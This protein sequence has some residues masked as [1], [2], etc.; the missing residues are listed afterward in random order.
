MSRTMNKLLSI[1]LSMAICLSFIPS[2]YSF[3][4]EFTPEAFDVM[5]QDSLT[6]D[7]S[8]AD[9]TA[10]EPETDV[11]WFDQSSDTVL[12]SDSSAY[13][14]SDYQ[15]DSTADVAAAFEDTAALEIVQADAEVL[16]E[17][18]SS[19]SDVFFT[20][21]MPAS[22]SAE[23][24]GLA[25]EAVSPAEEE[26]D[27]ENPVNEEILSDQAVSEEFFSDDSVLTADAAELSVTDEIV[28][29]PASSSSP[30]A[31]S[32][33]TE[34]NASAVS[35]EFF[36]DDSEALIYLTVSTSSGLL[37]L[38]VTD[39]ETGS[40]Q[41][42][43]YL[44]FPG[45][46][47]YSFHDD[48]GRYADMQEAFTVENVASQSFILT[49]EP[50]R[51][52]MSFSTAYV[53]PL[54]A[55]VITEADLPE[56]SVSAEESLENLQSFVES[57][58]YQQDS[59]RAR[60]MFFRNIVH[61]DIESAAADLRD[62][63]TT[64]EQTATIRMSSS[65]KP[66]EAQWKSLCDGIFSSAIAH[67]GYPTHGDYI[68]YEYG[69]YNASGSYASSTDGTYYYE[70]VYAPYYFTTAEQEQT[71]SGVVSSILSELDLEGKSNY[72]KIS[73]IYRYLCDNVSYG[74]SGDLKYTAYS[75]LVNK[76][77]YC[78]GYATAFYR[79][80][81]SVGV[82][83]RVITSSAMHHA[84]NIAQVDGSFYALD[85][86][87]DC[88]MQPTSYNY[89]LR[90]STY[91]LSNHKADGVSA[92]GD[93]FND[94]SFASAYGIPAAD[95]LST[96]SEISGLAIDASAFPDSVFRSYLADTFDTDGNGYFSESEI[97]AV[98]VIDCSGTEEAPG[99]I[100]SLQ[101]I[102][103]FPNLEQLLCGFND[104]ASL[105]IS[106]NPSLKLLDCSGNGLLFVSTISN[107]ALE[108]FAF[109][110]NQFTT[111]DLSENTA[112][113]ELDCSGNPLAALDLTP[114]SNLTA[115]S[116]SRCG[117][118]SLS[119]GSCPN[120]THL[121]CSGNE[122]KSL[123]LSP[124]PALT[125]VICDDNLLTELVLS[126]CA[127]LAGLL[128]SF[129]SLSS[130]DLSACTSLQVLVC[131]HNQ[132]SELSIIDC[133]ALQ[134]LV[135]SI[136][137]TVQ[138][139]GTICY[140]SESGAVLV[141]D[142]ETVLA[143]TLGICIDSTTFPDP[144]FRTLVSNLYDTDQNGYLSASETAAVTEINCAGTESVYGG[145][146]SLSGIEVF[147]ALETLVC[148][149][150]NL[151]ALDLHAN[152]ALQRLY[153]DNN[154]LSAL[155]V[156]SATALKAVNCSSNNI[157]S[158]ILGTNSSLQSLDCSYNKLVE[159]DLSGCTGLQNFSCYNNQLTALDLTGNT[160]LT[161]IGCSSNALQTL[162]LSS[163]RYLQHLTCTD[164]SL[165]SLN[166]NGC[167]ALTSINCS[168]NQLSALD[169]ESCTYLSDLRCQYNQLDNLDIGGCSVLSGLSCDHNKIANLDISSCPSLLSLLTGGTQPVS[170]NGITSYTLDQ[171]SW[172]VF[173][174]S[175]SLTT[176]LGLAVDEATFPD[177]AFRAHIL[178]N[179][180]LDH[181]LYLSENEISAV[182]SILCSG[183]EDAPG[184]IA[185]LAGIEYFT[186]LESLN[187]SYN[188]LSSLDLDDN[189]MLRELDCSCNQLSTA[190]FQQNSSLA[191]LNC[192]GNQLS[193]L[194]LGTALTELYCSSNALTSLDTGSLSSLRILCCDQNQ[195]A[196]IDTDSLSSLQT[197]D[198]SFN[199]VASLSLASNSSLETL[200]VNGT[201]LSSLDLTSL[202]SLKKLGA[203]LENLTR[204]DI[205]SV[206]A[207]V[208]AFRSGSGTYAL[209]PEISGTAYPASSADYVLF[210]GTDTYVI[211]GNMYTLSYEANGGSDA[212]AD[213]SCEEGV[214]TILS[215]DIPVR[216]GYHF[217]GWSDTSRASTAK[218]LSGASFIMPDSN[219][220]LYAVWEE[221]TYSVHFNENAP[222][223]LS[224]SGD[225]QDQHFTYGKTQSLRPN[226]YR[227]ANYIFSGWSLEAAGAKVYSDKESV[228]DLTS[229][230]NGIV[231]LYAL[232][233]PLATEVTLLSDGNALGLTAEVDMSKSSELSLQAEIFP[234]DADAGV[235]WT[236]S[237]KSVATVD[238]N[239]LLRFLKP[240]T[241]TITATADD[242][243]RT[244][245]SVV[246]TVYYID[247]SQRLTGSLSS[248]STVYAAETK[249]GLQVGDTASVQ[250]FGADKTAPLS[251][252]LFDY[253]IS[254]RSWESIV[255]FDADNASVTSLLPKKSVSIKASL[256]GDPLKRSVSITVKT[257]AA[258]VAR[259]DLV[260]E[261]AI[262]ELVTSSASQTFLLRAV[263]YNSLGEE[264]PLS[265]GMFTYRVTDGSRIAS[266]KENS[267]GTAA[268]TI[269]KNVSGAFT[270]TA[271]S[272]DASKTVCTWTGNVIDYTP[273][274]STSK[275]TMD[276]YGGSNGGSVTLSLSFSSDNTVTGD[277]QFYD[278]RQQNE[279]TYAIA[280]SCA[281]SGNSYEVILTPEEGLPNKRLSGQL[282]VPTAHGDYWLDLTLTLKSTIPSIRLSASPLNPFYTGCT[283]Q[284]LVSCRSSVE[285]AVLDTSQSDYFT[286]VD[287]WN[288]SSLS[289][290]LS[291]SARS[292]SIPSK[293]TA[294]VLVQIAGLNFPISKTVSIS[295]RISKP[296]YTLSPSSGT[297]YSGG[298]LSSAVVSLTPRSG[299]NDLLY[300][301]SIVVTAGS[302]LEHAYLSD[303]N[304]IVLVPDFSPIGSSSPKVGFSVQADEWSESLSFTYTIRRTS[305][306][307]RLRAASSTLTLS[308]RGSTVSTALSS[309]QSNTDLSAVSGE[310]TTTSKKAL[311]K[312][313]VSCVEGVITASIVDSSVPTGTYTYSFAPYY[314]DQK[315]SSVSIRVKITK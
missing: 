297:F 251:P 239:G 247:N 167:T 260:P 80:C 68:R 278:N 84:W 137:Q 113:T 174:D 213:I 94:A 35:V 288:G 154:Q 176:G 42:G 98:T 92:I 93:E 29:E 190:D 296:S 122:L 256:R 85:A 120:L 79:L 9:Y 43:T 4:D 86:T 254:T 227:L 27:S 46:Y 192:S 8:I 265:R 153:C 186:E 211:S 219:T 23:V 242:G 160:A 135:T 124:C 226:K 63:I 16:S 234:A 289:V 44:L 197:L 67:T 123:D 169:L 2:P 184:A 37:C 272:K 205:S 274:L 76:T 34:E 56:V 298:G 60:F 95:Y 214:I 136:A 112:L 183:T 284:I 83:V 41:Y 290:G 22:D 303:D 304:T 28:T 231:E 90:G 15:D 117:L 109:R 188:Q 181:N 199:P 118:T 108:S 58:E 224:V 171:S 196:S 287:E 177:A 168:D 151:E 99:S 111:L 237:S 87:W 36:L 119:V 250:I 206:P 269:R 17:E 241:V 200:L 187:C 65:S 293:L 305:S 39:S 48:S 72:E 114:L 302:G 175:V 10:E 147:T 307:P 218:W 3:A 50:V 275:I 155:D 246:F 225:M 230:D 102:A 286:V 253:T 141:Y 273:V 106:G 110:D 121:D 209:N 116:C 257:I 24:S 215:Q 7:D 308:S 252:D 38:P 195:L 294:T 158:L 21:D 222:T 89:F 5:E 77:A 97:T 180:D 238:S 299:S 159:L 69:G 228:I 31:A 312:L 32:D 281:G 70:F 30:V 311:G 73:A 210:V 295:Q 71:L 185:S 18:D 100:A 240:G 220:I 268:V 173:D 264:L 19:A 198:I 202:T 216:E 178:E 166:L 266:V 103:F 263:A 280:A 133:S 64:F 150:N 276:S 189:L 62:Q 164:C 221:N 313:Q 104:L 152:T 277:V 285:S 309:N 201:S 217:L 282:F 26:S 259:A 74:G 75:A 310:L 143:Y 140:A 49:L 59:G 212:P 233:T 53:N 129:N 235:A 88:G 134:T 191:V 182:N 105:D 14:F 1:C 270:I 261:S 127:N 172:L 306:L 40:A 267:D 126:S 6:A 204:L 157:S 130:L 145:I 203:Y 258:L 131:D 283:S 207:L 132:L 193:S 52:T 161:L 279:N 244:K 315:L 33:E 223:G 301:D 232:W 101:G 82:N 149:Y 57:L 96:G 271:T 107:P 91:W 13:D 12:M 54:Y 194:S 314:L 255:S 55:D 51:Q 163:L 11:I 291:D 47:T 245:A 248:V 229:E 45:D 249:S 292:G 170:E 148:S 144:V 208:T 236:S 146:S 162:D 125:Y 115:L 165:T 262:S 25:V 179:Y 138:E 78:Q 243:S 156:S 20:E 142:E 128:C 61:S 81:L 300:G 139:D 66:T